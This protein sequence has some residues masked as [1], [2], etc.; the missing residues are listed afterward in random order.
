M[1]VHV[2]LLR[3]VKNFFGVLGGFKARNCCPR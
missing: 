3:A 1:N 2:A